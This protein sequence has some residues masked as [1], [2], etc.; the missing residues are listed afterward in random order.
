MIFFLHTAFI[1]IYYHT[2]LKAGSQ[3]A[4]CVE[5]SSADLSH[6]CTLRGVVH[7]EHGPVTLTSALVTNFF[8]C[9]CRRAQ[10]Q[11]FTVFSVFVFPQSSAPERKLFHLPHSW[12]TVGLRESSKSIWK[13]QL[14]CT[15]LLFSF[16][17]YS[18]SVYIRSLTHC[19]PFSNKGKFICVLLTLEIPCCFSTVSDILL[20]TLHQTCDGNLSFFF[21]NVLSEEKA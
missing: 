18:G 19:I 5:L 2:D 4:D 20:Q 21:F 1:I 8:F 10:P 13:T 7:S 17:S 11:C 9:C 15:A 14:S 6:H 3:D 12:D 16:Y